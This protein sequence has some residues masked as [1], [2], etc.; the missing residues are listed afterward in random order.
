M[1][2]TRS[3]STSSVYTILDTFIVPGPG[4]HF[5]LKK[6]EEGLAPI[7]NEHKLTCDDPSHHHQLQSQCSEANCLQGVSGPSTKAS[8]D[9]SECVSESGNSCGRAVFNN[10]LRDEVMPCEDEISTVGSCC[11]L[12]DEGRTCDQ[13]G[14]WYIVDKG[15]EKCQLVQSCWDE[16]TKYVNCNCENCSFF[17]SGGKIHQDEREESDISTHSRDT[18]NRGSEV[19]KSQHKVIVST[20][21]EHKMDKDNGHSSLDSSSYDSS[22]GMAVMTEDSGFNSTDGLRYHI[23]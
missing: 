1:L 22:T 6:L 17:S 14:Q 7:E 2:T 18:R 11:S 13:T 5:H 15:T 10:H 8:T 9:D 19:S 4:H 12:E 20:T 21:D 3:N 23:V 16:D